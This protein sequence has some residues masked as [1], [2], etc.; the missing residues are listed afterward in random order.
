MQT[1]RFVPQ[2]STDG[3]FYFNL[4]AANG[5]VIATSEM[6]DTHAAM[7]KGIA[8]VR[9]NAG[10]FETLEKRVEKWAKDK[11]ILDNATII[12]QSEKTVEE[13]LEL[14]KAAAEGDLVGYN[15]ALG[16][17]LVT[18]IIG[19]KLRGVSLLDCLS[20]VL[21]IIEKRTGKMENGKFIKDTK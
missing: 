1:K 3:K 18:I 17:V 8:S 10:R 15:D 20:D 11:G 21:D 7:M 16:D 9:K 5:Q 4:L 12:S 13:A 2:R 14:E 6:Y 19:A